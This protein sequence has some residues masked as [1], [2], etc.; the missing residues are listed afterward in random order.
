MQ[1]IIVG[2]NQAGQRL[3]K[4][5]HKLLPKAGNGFL[6]KMLRKKNITLNNK[7]A[8]GNEIL[9]LGDEL[10]L[11]MKD[12]TILLF[13]EEQGSYAENTL[14]QGQMKTPPKPRMKM[15]ILYED[16]NIV[17]LNKPAGVLTQ[18]A[19]ASDYSLNEGLIDYLIQK[20]EF[21][22]EDLESFRP[23]VLN[24]LDRNTSGIVLC[25]KSLIGSQTL[26][27]A[28]RNRTIQKYY[29]TICTG[30]LTKRDDL[31][32]YISKDDKKNKVTIYKQ[33]MENTSFIHTR[34]TPIQNAMEYTLLEVELITGKTHQIRAHLASIG[35]PIIGDYKYGNMQ[36]NKNLKE[37]FGL[38]NQLLHAYRISFP[39][40]EGILAP[41]NG[42]EITAPYTEQFVKL[43]NA[44]I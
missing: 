2:K 14:M 44:L 13:K 10:K 24:R 32:G 11:F 33:E 9:S 6:Y 17:I 16:E 28:I 31:Q 18:K 15:D 42:K 34:F 19:Q 27:D 22:I 7:K 38:T 36:I 20:N 23:S 39:N 30:R 37:E 3:D 5:L 8:E 21:S 43:K 35:H 1:S 12:E 25:G 40:A 26:S 29:H 41:L 4:F